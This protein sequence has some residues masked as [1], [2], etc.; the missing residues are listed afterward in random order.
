M[1][2]LVY[3]VAMTVNQ[4]IAHEDESIEGFLT[5]GHH[6]TDYINS[7]R[8]YDTV[9]MGKR[10]Y[11][12]GYQFGINPGDA[13][14]VYGHMMQYVFSKS[15]T[16]YHT[17]GLQVIQEDAASFVKQ[18]KQQDGGSIYLSGGGKLAG[19]LLNHGLIDELILKVN[20]VLFA[21]GIPV[22]ENLTSDHPLALLDTKIY[23]NGT[24]FLH[25]AVL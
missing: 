18:L 12:W 20:P 25:Y 4:Y 3:Y 6:I 14:P 2:K 10:T 11:E 21:S 5:E 24:V 16:P 19:Y 15:M 17:E 8:D 22:L 1:R 7:L 13:V 23:N 9:L